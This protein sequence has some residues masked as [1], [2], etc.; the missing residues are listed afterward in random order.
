MSQIEYRELSTVDYNGQRWYQCE[1][2]TILPSITTVLGGT[3]PP[4][5]KKALSDWANAIGQAN[6]KAHTKRAC[7]RGENVHLMIE[8]MLRNED[9]NVPAA[10]DA[11]RKLFVSM[12][13]LLR[14][15]TSVYGLEVPLFSKVLGVA[16]RTDCVGEFAGVPSI[17]DFKTSG[18]PKSDKEIEDYWLQCT[19]YALAH[20]EMFG[21]DIRQGVIL[22]GVENGL[23]LMWKKDLYECITPLANRIEGFYQNMA[24]K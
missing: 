8:Q 11:D 15:I 13:L 1:A 20:N 7:I 18:K 12:K 23:P 16:G 10:S 19:F 4:E 21:T 22:M 5:K 2:D 17:I 14:R 9:I 6:A 3:Q 24:Q